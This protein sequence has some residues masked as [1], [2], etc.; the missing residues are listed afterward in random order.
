MK[1]MLA[2]KRFLDL[3]FAVLIVLV[4]WPFMLIIAL[5]VKFDS[6]GPA[7]F[8]QERLGKDGKPFRMYKFRSMVVDA[9]K[10][11]AGLFNYEGDPRV[12]KVGAF[13]RKT[14]LDELPQLFNI[15]KGDLSFVGPR[16]PV[17]YELGEF[18]KLNKKFRRRFDVKPGITGYAQVQ[19]R[20]EIP[21][22]IKV[23]Y[24]NQYIEKFKEWGV[25]FDFAIIFETVKSVV[26]QKNIYEERPENAEDDAEAA[27]IAEQEVI[28]MA[29]APDDENE[30]V[31]MR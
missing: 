5:A 19:G 26:A 20:N 18:S 7:L 6:K 8:K 27:A 15:I 3:I 29:Q 14:S 25:L 22:N 13:L 30:T 17:T 10:Q 24:D 2:L 12:T 28:R 11:G 9:E 23:E 21:W 4:I 16:P 31:T 1:P